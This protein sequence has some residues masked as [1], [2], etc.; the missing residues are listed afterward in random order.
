MGMGMGMGQILSDIIQQNFLDLKSK[1]LQTEE[2]N[3]VPVQMNKNRT[4]TIYIIM[5]FHKP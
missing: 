3:E 2:P 1:N 4:I 5:K